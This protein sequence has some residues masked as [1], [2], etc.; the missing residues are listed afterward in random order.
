MP[1]NADFMVSYAQYVVREKIES[2]FDRAVEL[3]K[4]A[5]TLV[6]E[7]QRCDAYMQLGYFFQ[8]IKRFGDAEK[9]FL[10]VLELWPDN[11]GAIYQL[12]RNAVFSGDNLEKGLSYFEEYLKHQPQGGDPEWADARW[13][14]GMIYEKLGDK[15]KAVAQYKEAL[16]LNPEH[17]NSKEA[18]KKLG[19]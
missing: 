12:G 5:V 16:K 17:Q 8:Q 4:K 10:K 1:D 19:A 9:T 14:M 18:L 15:Q 11:A 13:R 3:A 2:Q 6:P 7:K